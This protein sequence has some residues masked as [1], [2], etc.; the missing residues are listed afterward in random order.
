MQPQGMLLQ[1][2]YRVLE[3]IGR[4]GM[5]SVYLAEDLRLHTTVALKQMLVSGERL[6][7]AFNREAQL[8]AALRH[9]SIPRVIDH[10]IDQNG[11][12][13]VMEYIP[14]DDVGTLLAKRQQPFGLTDVLLWAD[15]LL[16]ALDYLH[17]H[18]PP[19]IH[20]D[21]KPQNLKLT[22]KNEI[23]L[24]DFGLAKMS[25]AGV[26]GGQ[27]DSIFGYTPHYAPLEQIQGQ[28]TDARTDLY[29]LAATLHHLLTSSMP[30]DAVTRA[31][32]LVNEEPDP[33]LPASEL[34]PQVP[35]AIAAVLMQAMSQKANLRPQS[36]AEMRESLRIAIH[37]TPALDMPT[38]AGL[39]LPAR[40]SDALAP[41]RGRSTIRLPPP[42][43]G[44]APRRPVWQLALAAVAALALAGA[45][46]FGWISSR[47]GDTVA[48]A[49]S[50]PAGTAAPSAAAPE[51]MSGSL[52]IAVAN[53]ESTQQSGCVVKPDEARGLAMVVYQSLLEQ[54]QTAKGGLSAAGAA[55]VELGDIEIRSPEQTGSLGTSGDRARAA[56]Q[57]ARDMNADVVLYGEVACEEAPRQTLLTPQIYISDRKLQSFDQLLFI[58]EHAFGPQLASPGLPASGPT[59]QTIAERLVP[60]MGV[61]TQFLVGL[62][63]YYA[64]IY[65][66]AATAFKAANGVEGFEDSFITSMVSL[67]EGTTASRREQYQEAKASYQKVLAID[68]GNQT[69]RYS[70]ADATYYA[71]RGDCTSDENNP[72]SA[73]EDTGGLN[74][75]LQLFK[76]VDA[77]GDTVL[78]KTVRGMAA[79]GMGQVYV[80]MSNA[81]I[82]DAEGKTNHWS[83][84]E[85]QFQQAIQLLD[86]EGAFT[87]DFLAEAHAGLAL[88]YL[89]D[90]NQQDRATVDARWR[91]AAEEYCTASKLSGYANRQAVFRH[92]LAAIH[93]YVGEYDQ[94]AIERE[95]AIVY[96]PSNQEAYDNSLHKQWLAD[97]ETS[98]SKPP[99]WTCKQDE[100]K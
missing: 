58:G 2:R 44:V 86:Q 74:E 29:A 3:H 34:N 24:L 50:A 59:R 53:F 62:D 1:E 93:G 33:L 56:E 15:Q 27:N 63:Y 71:S 12:F 28:G 21:I 23:I 70:L 48:Q 14:G 96:D 19:V 65:D 97:K 69:A 67:Y 83:A 13:L 32:S 41:T 51:P 66:Q 84:A 4:G 47:S 57:K 38:R 95:K 52:N 81:I 26:T 11:Q 99:I 10:F 78:D 77:P 82:P 46:V 79:F 31:G 9:P 64:G 40:P 5:G 7:D 6:S 73:G 25:L 8:L 39:R 80:C 100:S 68:S 90:V 22:A 88:V 54:M 61:L 30:V 72:A 43:P 94:A 60:R 92:R 85:Q 42:A 87:Q 91:R 37:D 16:A 35:P 76:Q 36:A 20:R 55:Q 89:T 18:S 45:G 17:N 49:T 98:S 75:A